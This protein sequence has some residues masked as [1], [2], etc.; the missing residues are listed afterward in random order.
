MKV[1]YWYWSI[2]LLKPH[3]MNIGAHR[4]G[5]WVSLTASLDVLEM[6]KVTFIPDGN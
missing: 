2:D 5:G 3:G 6:T 4:I 1:K